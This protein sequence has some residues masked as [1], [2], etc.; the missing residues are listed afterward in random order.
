MLVVLANPLASVAKHNFLGKT[1]NR[2]QIYIILV[3]L[4][5]RFQFF[6]C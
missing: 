1:I 4:K 6:N 5:E 3:L 2:A